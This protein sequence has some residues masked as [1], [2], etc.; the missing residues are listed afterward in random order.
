MDLK[1]YLTITDEI[2]DA[3]QQG[4]PVVALESTILSHGMPYPENLEF[5]HRVEKIIR[6]EGAVPA[7]AAIIKGVLKI[8]LNDE[9]L[10][11]MCKAENVGKVSRRDIPVYVA[12]GRTGATT[13]ASTMILASLA[14]IKIFATGGIGGVHR[15]ATETMD[16]SADLQE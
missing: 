13:V 4:K 14:G 16:I 15:G 2:R 3:L 5:A 6:D 8:G 9:E 7:T 12:T 10:E 11:I 1:K